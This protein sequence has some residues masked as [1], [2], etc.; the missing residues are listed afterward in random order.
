MSVWTEQQ[1]R[2]DDDTLRQKAS[3]M[4]V[5]GYGGDDQDRETVIQT[6]MP[7]DES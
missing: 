3:E 1:Q 2:P 7:T 6:V 5:G 4:G